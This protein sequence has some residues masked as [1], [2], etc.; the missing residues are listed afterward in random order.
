MAFAV[1]VIPGDARLFRRIHQLHYDSASGKISSAAFKD[2]RMSVNWEKYS[3]AQTAADSNSIGVAA[4]IADECSQLG[5]ALEHTPIESDQP[6]GPNQSHS[7]ICGR[8]TGSTSRQ[9]RDIAR[10]VWQRQ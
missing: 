9:L 3:D 1:E 2:E 4:L 10:L 8:K 6:F 5:Q 7:E